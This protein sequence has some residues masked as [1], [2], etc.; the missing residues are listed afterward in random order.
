MRCLISSKPINEMLVQHNRPVD[1]FYQISSDFISTQGTG[2]PFLFIK[3]AYPE[4]LYRRQNMA[5]YKRVLVSY[6]G[7]SCRARFPGALMI[8]EEKMRNAEKN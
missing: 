2:I 6:F 3:F 4:T 5:V 7:T 1:C 8:F